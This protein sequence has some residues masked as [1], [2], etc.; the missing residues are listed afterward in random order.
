ML[1]ICKEDKAEK[2]AGYCKEETGA[3]VG[4]GEHSRREM[5]ILLYQSSR[6]L[7]VFF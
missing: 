1:K 5:A 4:W 3:R 7:Y 6:V 2:E